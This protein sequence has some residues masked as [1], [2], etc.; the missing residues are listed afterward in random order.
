MYEALVN[1]DPDQYTETDD[2]HDANMISYLIDVLLLKRNPVFPSKET[3]PEI[4][5]VKQ[6]S[7][8]GRAALGEHP[9]IKDRTNDK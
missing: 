5:A 3:D 8:I 7:S 9:E 4:S 2:E 1:R 6:W